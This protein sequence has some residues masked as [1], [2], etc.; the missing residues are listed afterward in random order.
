ME[1]YFIGECECGS[2]RIRA[3]HESMLNKF[4][5]NN[6]FVCPS[7]KSVLYKQGEKRLKADTVPGEERE[8]ILHEKKKKSKNKHLTFDNLR[9]K[10]IIDKDG[11]P[12]FGT[13]SYKY[14]TPIGHITDAISLAIDKQDDDLVKKIFHNYSYEIK[15][16]CWKY[17]AKKRKKYLKNL[18]PDKL[19][20]YE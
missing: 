8:Y 12:Q 14:K 15:I 4:I 7:C 19:S 9:D 1:T 6:N 20:Q 2:K 5:N 11:M 18:F 16:D 3:I 13:G 17:L 10:Y